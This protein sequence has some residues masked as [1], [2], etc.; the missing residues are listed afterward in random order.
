[1]DKKILAI[2]ATAIF[3]SSLG[4]VYAGASMAQGPTGLAGTNGTNGTSGTSGINGTNGADGKNG[5]NGTDASSHLLVGTNLSLRYNSSAW[6]GPEYIEL[7]AV[8]ATSSNTFTIQVDAVTPY[9][10][11]AWFYNITVVYGATTNFY[12]FS[13]HPTFGFGFGMNEGFQEANPP[14][15]LGLA[16]QLAT[17]TFTMTSVLFQPGQDYSIIIAGSTTYGGAWSIYSFTLTP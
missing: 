8:N 13:G 14:I 16:P 1:M 10:N 2:F 7:L 4:G 17:I 11:W 6:N 12:N 5:T 15:G 9:S 3:L